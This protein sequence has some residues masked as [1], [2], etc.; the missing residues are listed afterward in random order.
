VLYFGDEDVRIQQHLSGSSEALQALEHYAT[1]DAVCRQQTLCEYL[2]G[3]TVT[4]VCG[5]CDVCRPSLAR[6]PKPRARKPLTKRDRTIILR[7]MRRL[8]RAVLLEALSRALRGWEVKRLGRGDLLTLPELGA[9]ER[10][11]DVAL[12][13]AFDD[14]VEEGVL[15]RRR[16]PRGPMLVLAGADDEP[17]YQERALPPP[18]TGI[19]SIAPELD[20]ACRSKARELSVRP[21]ALLPRRTIVAIDR[22]RPTTLDELRRVPGMRESTVEAMGEELLALVERY[23]S[24][25]ERRP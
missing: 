14:L 6:A 19:T 9:L 11:D 7:A 24:S 4:D 20:R 25:R 13:A 17:T 23:A 18:T 8:N 2:E 1:T 12:R 10:H 16:S 5:R 21:S 22:R 15:R 3:R